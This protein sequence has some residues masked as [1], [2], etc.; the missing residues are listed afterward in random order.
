MPASRRALIAA[1][2]SSPERDR[3]LAHLDGDPA[4]QNGHLTGSALVV[5]HQ[6][7]RTLVL[8]HRK[9][10]KWL[11]PGGHVE[12]GDRDLAATALREATEETGIA[13]LT[14]EHQ[15][16]DLDVHWVGDH[17]HY[18]VRYVVVAPAGAEPSGNHESI[19]L[20]WITTDQLDEIGADASLRRLVVAANLVRD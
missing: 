2:P 10:G 1:C 18:D 5:D 17:F 3:I 19:A 15:P 8:F 4:E 6:R 16:A 9:L 20:R 14:V 12:P 11:Q 13:G 7:A